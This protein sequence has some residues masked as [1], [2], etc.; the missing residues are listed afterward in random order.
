[1][2][3][4]LC[5]TSGALASSFCGEW[6]RNGARGER[7][8]RGVGR[9]PA[10]DPQPE[11]CATSGQ[12]DPV[13]Q[14]YFSLL[15]PRYRPCP[16]P[17]LRTERF[18]PC[19][20]FGKPRPSCWSV[21]ASWPERLFWSFLCRTPGAGRL[22]PAVVGEGCDRREQPRLDWVAKGAGVALWNCPT[23][24]VQSTIRFVWGAGRCLSSAGVIPTWPN[25]D[26]N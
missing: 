7:R 11:A 15:L 26:E 10:A 12:R 4:R 19:W 9:T 25:S 18:A 17:R 1:M 8:Q 22:D 14:L 16:A 21:P 6:R 2:G 13:P 20:R 3:S 23:G 24:R 5:S